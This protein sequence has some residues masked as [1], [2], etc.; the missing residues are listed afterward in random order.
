MKIQIFLLLHEGE[1]EKN[2]CDSVIWHIK[3]VGVVLKWAQ[4]PPKSKWLIFYGVPK[5]DGRGQN[6]QFELNMLFMYKDTSDMRKM[7]FFII[8][9]SKRVTNNE[10]NRSLVYLFWTYFDENAKTVKNFNLPNAT[11]PPQ[12]IQYSPNLT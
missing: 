5:L 6:G 4:P 3:G 11:P 1:C 9:L 8:S 12:M 2:L 7:T 10:R